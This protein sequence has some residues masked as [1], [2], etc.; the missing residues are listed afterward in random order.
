MIQQHIIAR[1]LVLCA[2]FVAGDVAG[3]VMGFL[4]DPIGNRAYAEGKAAEAVGDLIRARHAWTRAAS[5][6]QID[7]MYELGQDCMRNHDQI[8]A[9]T[10][11]M[12]ATALKHDLSMCALGYC[13]YYVLG[14]KMLA[15]KAIILREINTYND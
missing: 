8:G 5:Q 4:W 10:H 14:T 3:Y 12:Q 2:L 15:P 11:W 13:I 6:G 7:A 9:V 1:F